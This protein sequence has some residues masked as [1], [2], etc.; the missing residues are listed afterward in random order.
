MKNLLFVSLF[1]VSV[2]LFESAD[3]SDVRTDGSCKEE[4][5][6]EPM[7]NFEETN[8]N[9]EE[10]FSCI[11]G[12]GKFERK[13]SDEMYSKKNQEKTIQTP[14]LNILDRV[15]VSGEEIFCKM[16]IFGYGF[17]GDFKLQNQTTSHFLT[18]LARFTS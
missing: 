12:L 7:C 4:N 1:T 17:S 8:C 18:A 11:G 2:R 10:P 6:G 5:Y 3:L 16:T 15:K 9:N 14:Y 13:V